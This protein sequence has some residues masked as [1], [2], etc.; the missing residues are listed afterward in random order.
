MTDP[1][2]AEK[3]TRKRSTDQAY[4]PD[5][6]ELR[7][8]AEGAIIRQESLLTETLSPEETHRILH[9]LRV[10]QIELEMQNEELRRAQAE[11]DASRA[12][13]FD[14]YDLAPVG[15]CTVS[16]KGIILK[17]NLTAANMLGMARSELVERP[18][19]RLIHKEDED[20]FYLLH[21]RL[22]ETSQPQECGLRMIKKDSTAIWVWMGAILVENADGI[23]V[24]YLAISDITARKQ[25]EKARDNANRK[26]KHEKDILQAVMNGATNSHLVYLDRDF[27]FVHVNEAYARTCGYRPEQMIGKN[28]FALYPHAEN[29]AIFVRVRDT[30]EQVAF[31]DK[32][33][34]FPDQPERGMTYWDWTL[35]PV[36]DQNGQVAGL[37][38]SLIETTTRKCMEQALQ[39]SE[40]RY[41]ALVENSPD[42]ITRFDRDLKLI[43]ANPTVFQRTGKTMDELTGRTAQEYGASAVS[44]RLWDQTARKAL[45]T[46]QPQRFESTSVWQGL[47]R[48]Y[49]I[50]LI[51]EYGPEGSINSIMNIAR[52]ITERK[53]SEDELLRLNRTLRALGKSSKALM[54]AAEEDAY[55]QEVCR[56][57]VEDCGHAMVWIGFAEDDEAQ[58]VRPVASSG[59]E[60]GYLETLRITW[61]DTERGRGPT[62][63]AIRTGLPSECQNMLT[64]PK[65]APWRDEA[66]RRGYSSSIVLP[67]RAE[68][69]TFGALNIYSKQPYAFSETEVGLLNE[70][71]DDLAFGIT[72]LRIRAAHARA[73]SALRESEQQVRRKLENLLSP[74]G[75]IGN[76]ELSEIIN[77]PAI[78][79]LMGKFYDLTQIPLAVID[80]K[81]KVLVGAGWQEIC[82][83]FHRIHPETCGY[84]IESDTLLTAGMPAGEYKLYKCKNNMWDVATPIEV[85]GK[86]LGHFFTGQFF[87]DDESPDY[88]FFRAQAKH[89][90]FDEQEYLAA[91]DMVPRLS[92]ATVD[93]VMGFFIDLS[94][95]ISQLSYS[96]IKLARISAERAML[97]DEIRQSRDE[98]ELRVQERTTDLEK[99]NEALRQSN[100]ALE[101][102]A[103]VASHDLQEPLR[104]IMTF[105]ERLIYA[106]TGNLNDQARDYLERMQNAAARMQS[107]IQDLVKYS[108]V[109]SSPG[110]FKVLNL[111]KPVV[112]AVMDLAVLIEENEGR[113]E[114]GGLPDA[115][116]NESQMRQLFQNLIGNSLKYRSSQKPI[117]RIYSVPS[118]GDG[119]N[120]IHVEDNGIGFDEQFLDKIFKPFQRLHG[121]SSPIQGTGMGLAICKKIVEFHGGSITAKSELGKGST[122]IMR[123]PKTH[124]I[125]GEE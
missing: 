93:T 50:I 61:A 22:M 58:S 39:E 67:L 59:F 31:H 98:L 41:R 12:R 55:L 3:E 103:H 51:P 75:D 79:T 99:I 78:Q 44:T 104:K 120:E 49:D 69:K 108:R 5:P 110:H 97:I 87:F 14:L 109:T 89:Y 48:I 84:C 125:R 66:I 42:L 62:G 33:F 111:K 37:V 83:K 9:E 32:P 36:K 115:K 1:N 28:H 47:V 18:I 46:G 121:K 74:E 38:F 24:S 118:S 117:I 54:R 13:Y 102:F 29:E 27:N 70:L 35:T 94:S 45:E 23:P 25:A 119:L 72:S 124:P 76:L 71:A 116:A 80:V 4:Y 95:M 53:Q 60:A 122:F 68:G 2:D 52:D 86:Q 107:L 57:I 34:E 8:Q 81:G 16:E 96:N 123:L 21:K 85:G 19:T 30:G 92:R 43:Y 112:E 77:A 63:T 100:M 15:Y 73:E 26:V 82:T 106:D 101:D 40:E 17:A 11:L 64:D 6:T 7:R 105:S 20:I 91:L 90:G 10:H 56:I 88:E 114:I 65:F 113:I